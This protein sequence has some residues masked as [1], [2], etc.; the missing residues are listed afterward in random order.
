MFRFENLARRKGFRLIIGIDEAG[1][2]PLAGP[3]VASAVCLKKR[4]FRSKICDSKKINSRQREEAFEEILQNAYVGVGM[5]NESV[6]DTENI[7]KATFLAMA[8]AVRQLIERFP[9]SEIEQGNF[10]NDVC[11]LVDGNSFKTDLPYAYQ[12]IIGGD[13]LSASIACASIV[14]KVTRDRILNIYDRVFPQYGFKQHKGY[15]TQAHRAA[16]Q[17]HGLSLIH[18]KTFRHFSRNHEKVSQSPLPPRD[19]VLNWGLGR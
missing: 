11:L 17:T 2:G 14:A 19:P 18:R 12:T 6:I 3:V 16:I 10:R 4:N 7:L 8:Q 1:R 15:P 13:D 9:A 5:M